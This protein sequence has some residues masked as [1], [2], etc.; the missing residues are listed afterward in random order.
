MPVAFSQSFVG[1]WKGTSLCQVKNSPCHDEV[2][3]YHVTKAN[4]NYEVVANKI[5]NNEEQ[6]MG[7]II[8]TF[9][10]SRKIYVSRDTVRNAEW[11]FTL[12]GNEIKGTLVY[13][14]ELYRLVDVKRVP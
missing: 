2:V 3:V 6:Y 5:V 8:F 4:A 10:E 14:N 1:T 12:S 11:E 9:D 7:T 13:K